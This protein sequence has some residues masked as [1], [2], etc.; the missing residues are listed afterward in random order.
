MCYATADR[1]LVLRR[2]QKKHEKEQ[3]GTKGHHPFDGMSVWVSPHDLT[4][5]DDF[6]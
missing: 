6:I 2:L 3:P 4:P 1:D 5:D